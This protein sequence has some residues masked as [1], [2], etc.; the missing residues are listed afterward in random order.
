[1]AC[2]WRGNIGYRLYTTGLLEQT[3]TMLYKRRWCAEECHLQCG[4]TLKTADELP[5]AGKLASTA[6]ENEHA[7]YA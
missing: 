1:M 2:F 4:R 7:P 3:R 6:L 5:A